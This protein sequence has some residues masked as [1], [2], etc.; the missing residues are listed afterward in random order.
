M[1]TLEIQFVT[2]LQELLKKYN[3]GITAEDH[4]RGYAE[5]GQDLQMMVFSPG[6]LDESGEYIEGLG[7]SL[8][9]WIDSTKLYYRGE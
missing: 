2:E 9:G 7:F 4:Y 5:C 3:A 6:H 8:G 1:N